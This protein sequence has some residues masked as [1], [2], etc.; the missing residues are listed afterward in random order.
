MFGTIRTRRTPLNC[1]NKRLISTSKRRKLK[2]TRLQRKRSVTAR[3][4]LL[5]TMFM[6]QFLSAIMR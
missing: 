4:R 5:A 2:K 6:T 3:S 1:Y